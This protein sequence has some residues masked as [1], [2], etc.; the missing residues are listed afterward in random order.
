MLKKSNRMTT[1]EFEMVWRS[2][3]TVYRGRAV[4]ARRVGERLARPKLAMVVGKKTARK[5][6][7]RNRLRRVGYARLEEMLLK[8][9][10]SYVVI[11]R[12]TDEIGRRRV[13]KEC[14]S[15]SSPYH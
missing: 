3:R 4:E 9:K 2:G 6:V 12:A 15:R 10:D 11:I 7:D 14:R 13:G 8:Q 5:A 1:R